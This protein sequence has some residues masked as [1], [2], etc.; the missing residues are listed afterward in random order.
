MPSSTAARRVAPAAP[1]VRA[2]AG[3]ADPWRAPARVLAVRL[4][5]L[6]DVLMTTPALRAMRQAW[7]K[8][9]LTLL[10]SPAGAALAPCLDSVDEV[11]ATQV[12]WMKNGQPGDT[13]GEAEAALVERLRAGHHDAVV[14]F[15]VCT[16]SAL[17]AALLCRMAGIPARLAHC[18]EN[19]YG[20]LTHWVPDTDQ[21]GDHMRHEVQRQLDLVA[22]VGAAAP[23]ARR[24]CLR[25][26]PAHHRAAAA[27]LR[28][29]G[30]PRRQPYLVVHP[31]ATAPSRRWPATRFGEAADA[32]AR[33]AGLAVVFIGSA[34]EQ[35]LIDEARSVMSRPA[36]SL[37]GQVDAPALAAL[38]AA[39][40]LLL[41]NNSGPSHLA[42]ATGTPVVTLYAQTNPQHTPWSARARVLRHDVPCRHCLRS[43]CP[44]GHHR[45]LRELQ[46]AQVLDAAQSLLAGGAARPR[47]A[48]IELVHPP[49]QGERAA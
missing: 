12:P 44:E 11:Q 8:A 46:V 10:T 39:A 27:A 38:I 22:T 19:P 29:A 14:I 6:G 41:A 20:L 15:T 43:V 37:A 9:H 21:V 42:A 3:D 49:A 17:P 45:C 33:R 2:V 28:T 5:Q 32:L 4:D 34:A 13:P 24:L 48:R 35:P 47:A 16:Q 40:R 30:L 7:P 26:L 25:L 1:A 31:G 23:A 18:R 36:L